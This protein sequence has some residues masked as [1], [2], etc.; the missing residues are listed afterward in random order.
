MDVCSRSPRGNLRRHGVVLL[1]PNV[2]LEV[3]Q[4]DQVCISSA[5]VVN[6][7]IMP[8]EYFNASGV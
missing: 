6:C 8:S 7:A 5:V 2:E 1:T 3:D 4:Y